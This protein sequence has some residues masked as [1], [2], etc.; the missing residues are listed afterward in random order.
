MVALRRIMQSVYLHSHYLVRHFGLTGPQLVILQ[1]LSKFGELS[2][3]ELSK[4]TS[5]S[6]ATVTG[7]LERLEK[8]ELICRRRSEKDRRRVLVHA[9][10]SCR[11]LLDQ[12]PPPLQEAF[13]EQFKDLEN[14]EQAMILSSLQRLVSMMDA[15]KIKAA[16]ILATGPIDETG[17]KYPL[18]N[19]QMTK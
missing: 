18:K 12:A 3:G 19:E 7:I 15:G 14:W 2:V 10:E 17:E 4:A 5:L 13:I 6:Q 16:P 11:Q 9:T 1:E 8:R